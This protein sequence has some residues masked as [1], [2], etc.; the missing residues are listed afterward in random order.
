VLRTTMFAFASVFAV[1]LAQSV[2]ANAAEAMAKEEVDV[3]DQPNAN[4]N[5]IAT[6][7]E[8][9]MV[10][11]GECGG[12]Y[13]SIV[14][15]PGK[16]GWV[17]AAALDLNPNTSSARKQKSAAYPREVQVVADADIHDQ[18]G[19]GGNVIGMVRQ[20]TTTLTRKCRADNWCPVAGG[21]V[22]GD[23]IVR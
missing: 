12:S 9:I 17:R 5:V 16:G 1:L 15:G 19:G 7:K 4:G 11:L 18:P 13:C 22:W 20:G 3:Y 21:W 14:R 6:L 2:S 8:G 23:F 10:D